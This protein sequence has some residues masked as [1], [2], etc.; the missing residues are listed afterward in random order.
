M[1]TWHIVWLNEHGNHLRRKLTVKT[2]PHG[3]GQMAWWGRMTVNPKPADHT[4]STLSMENKALPPR[5]GTRAALASDQQIKTIAFCLVLAFLAL[6]ML[7]IT[8]AGSEIAYYSSAAMFL[9]LVV[10]GRAAISFNTPLTLPFLLFG[11][12]SLI[13][14]F[15]ALDKP[16]SLHDYLTHFLK[17]ILLFFMVLNLTDTEKKINRLAWVIVA[18]ASLFCSGALVHEYLI[19]NTSLTSRFGLKLIETPTNLIG[20]V[21]LFAMILTTRLFADEKSGP[22]RAALLVMVSPVLLVTVLTQT[23]SNF[24]AMFIVIPILF[25]RKRKLL[26]VLFSLLVMVT[27]LSPVKNR[28]RV[29]GSV[30]HRISLFLLST[31]VIKDYPI[32]GIGFGIN[33]MADHQL[34]SPD[35]YNQRI[36]EKYRLPDEHFNWPH[37]MFLNIA[38]RTGLVG[39]GLYIVLLAVCCK[40][41]IQLMRFGHTAF[42]RQWANCILAALAMFFVKGNLEP[43]FSTIPEI[44]LVVIFSITAVLWRMDA[45]SKKSRQT[46]A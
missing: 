30:H 7:A 45:S 43:I 19:L 39:L 26:L 38:V 16:Y 34:I 32:T 42:I 24:V 14:L 3:T 40:C 17:L 41:L 21:T 11:T 9:F 6:S 25:Y 20:V 27:I 13:G 29:D 15:F 35:L 22:L 5:A 37:N 44:I 28:L 4:E 18:S 12:W 1:L 33:S 10:R 31:E 8:T 36:P 46:G 2:G 23:R